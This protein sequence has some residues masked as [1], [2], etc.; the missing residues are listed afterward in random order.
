MLHLWS[1]ETFRYVGA[2]EQWFNEGVTEYLTFRLATKLGI[3]DQT[4]VLNAFSTPVSNY[5]SAN[6]IGEYSLDSAAATPDLKRQHYFLLYHG[7][8]VAGMVL[9]HQIRSKSNGRHTIDDLMRE[10]YKKHSRTKLYTNASILE[11]INSSMKLD[12]SEFFKRYVYTENIIPV[13]DYF[14]LGMLKLADAGV[15]PLN[16]KNQKILANML[17]LELNQD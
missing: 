13:G 3:L 12:F 6:G 1:A 4:Q 10:I 15:V 11:L 16:G 9:D 17:M 2:Q 5:L 8:F 14:D 7:G